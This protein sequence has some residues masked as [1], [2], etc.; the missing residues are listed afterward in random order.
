[1]NDN[2]IDDST[3]TINADEHQQQRPLI[4]PPATKP[5]AP[6]TTEQ[7][8]PPEIT[9]SDVDA[10]ELFTGMDTP[11]PLEPFAPPAT[12]AIAMPATVDATE[13][14]T[15]PATRSILKL[16]DYL[17]THVPLSVRNAT[18]RTVRDAVRSGQVEGFVHLS[19]AGMEVLS[20]TGATVT[21]QYPQVLIGNSAELA[22]QLDVL[23]AAAARAEL[24]RTGGEYMTADEIIE[25]GDAAVFDE[26]VRVNRER[27]AARQKRTTYELARRRK[28]RKEAKRR[29]AS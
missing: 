27:Q 23:C 17:T 6:L 5:P 28:A 13:L 21:R 9:G 3:P 16:L 15:S 25:H 14:A 7:L 11:P 12:E 1:M 26:L 8:A 10:L 4:T 19:R 29:A 22:A 2:D 18:Y 24:I 20:S